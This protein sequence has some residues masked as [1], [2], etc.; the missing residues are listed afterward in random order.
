MTT[1]SIITAPNPPS[2][3]DPPVP[4]FNAHKDTHGSPWEPS[5]PPPGYIEVSPSVYHGSS[6][7]GNGERAVH[8]DFSRPVANITGLLA[9]GPDTKVE[10]LGGFSITYADGGV[11]FCGATVSVQDLHDPNPAGYSITGLIPHQKELEA[12]E[13]PHVWSEEEARAQPANFEVNGEKIH[14]V[15]V[16]AGAYLNGIQFVTGSGRESP[17]WG[18]CGG[19]ASVVVEA[20]SIVEETVQPGEEGADEDKGEKMKVVGLKIVLGSWRYNRG[21]ADVRPL[22]VQVMGVVESDRHARNE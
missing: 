21:Y 5:P 22:A 11:A 6:A 15:N 9:A 13:I 3:A 1:F 14:K 18:K 12:Q 7:H 2:A 10:R 20:G 16:W 17:K 19:P 4:D 8:L